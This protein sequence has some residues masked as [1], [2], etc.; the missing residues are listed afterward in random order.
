MPPLKQCLGVDLGFNTVKIV[1]LVADRRGVRVARAASA[2]T[3][4][5]AGMS[6]DELRA[7]IVSTTRELLKKGRFSSRK[8]V[9]SISGQ[10]VFVRRFRLPKTNED[11]LARIIQYEARQQIPFPL[12]KTILQWQHRNLE[13]EGEVEVLLVAIRTDEVR[14]FMT[15][16]GKTGLTPIAIGVS[17]FALHNAHQ[18]LAMTPAEMAKHMEAMLGKD[19]EEGK[20]AKPAAPGPAAAAPAKKGFSLGS[21]FKKKGAA[22]APA[23][24]APVATEEEEAPAPEFTYREVNGYLNIGATSYDLAIPREAGLTGF[25]RTV[26]MGGN[27]MTRGIQKAL[28]V[29]SFHDAERI[30]TSSTRMMTFQ[31]DFEEE[32]DVNRDA[33][34]AVSEVADRMVTSIRQSLDFYITQPDGMAIDSLLLSGGQSTI[35][36]LDNYLEEKLTLPVTLVRT[37]PEGST[38]TWPEES[39]GPITNYLIAMGLALQGVNAAPIKVDF[40]PEE[41]KIIRD[42]PYRV[43]F[44][45]AGFVVATAVVAS[46][47]GSEFSSKYGRAAG[48]IQLRKGQAETTVQQFRNAQDLHDRTAT[49]FVGLDKA[50]GQRD[51]WL[52][53]MARLA[54]TKP[55]GILL[56]DVQM[57][58]DGVMIITAQSNVQVDAATFNQAIRN[59]FREELRNDPTIESVNQLPPPAPGAEAPYRFTLRATFKSKVN[60]LKI[61]PTPTPTPATGGINPEGGF[62]PGGPGQPGGRPGGNRRGGAGAF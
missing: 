33:S 6:A 42:F 2:P 11:R 21:L 54:G 27:E 28:A 19:K 4:A 57:D 35:P 3:G 24:E 50:F 60:H 39:A 12:D 62:F 25:I 1:E 34:A 43:S 29:E 53:V 30:K 15:T 31:F 13:E 45:M 14:D 58:H 23:Q 8:A 46:Q 56:T 10:K 41:R 18:V 55:P 32:G 59:E 40:L 49:S 47:A 26:P 5:A 51:F 7:V 48:D 38:I 37:P 22:P 61:T 20:D 16:I 17:S 9:F 52:D 36:G 44:V